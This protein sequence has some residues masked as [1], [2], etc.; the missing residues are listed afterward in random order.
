[1]VPANYYKLTFRTRWKLAV[2]P[3]S[4]GNSLIYLL[5]GQFNSVKFS[6]IYIVSTHN[7]RHSKVLNIVGKSTIFIIMIR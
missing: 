6:P 4:L 3:G 5:S 1:M 2:I 7:N